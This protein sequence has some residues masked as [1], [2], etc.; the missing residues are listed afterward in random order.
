MHN[1]VWGVSPHMGGKAPHMQ[2]KVTRESSA[3]PAS[4]GANARG[5]W[6]AGGSHPPTHPPPAPHTQK[7]PQKIFFD[8]QRKR[9]LTF[10]PTH[11]IM[12]IESEIAPEEIVR[13][14]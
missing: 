14:S 6:G 8:L 1:V 5:V 11:G 13:E 9:V 4:A 12:R 7:P 2:E 3:S 10:P